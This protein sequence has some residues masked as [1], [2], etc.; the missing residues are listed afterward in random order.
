LCSLSA[1]GCSSPE[2][3]PKQARFRLP[4][5]EA[6]AAP[7]DPAGQQW[8]LHPEPVLSP[9]PTGAWDASDVLNPSVVRVNESFYNL[10][11]GFDGETWRTGLAASQDG[12]EWRKHPEPVLS[13]DP[14]TWEGGYIAANGAAFHDGER[15]LYWYHA[16]PRESPRIGLA[17]S[18]DAVHWTKQP[19]PVLEPGAPG[20]WDEA[21]VADPYAIRCQ[22]SYYL[23]FLG[24]NRFG[25]Q[26]LGVA[27]SPDGVHWQKSHTNPILD[28]GPPGSFDERGLGE[29]AVVFHGGRFF[30]LYTGRDS[31]E[32]RRL[33]W[34]VSD[35][36]VNWKKEPQARI[37]SVRRSWNRAVLCDATF[38]SGPE[39]LWM[40]FGGGD[41]PRPDE[42]LNGRIG[43]A[44]V[45]S[46]AS[47]PAVR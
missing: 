4:A 31:A 45:E 8:T 27:R 9:G 36:G 42:N 7:A 34:A 24:Q 19:A 22:G 41:R 15:F 18:Q 1:A 3:L 14:R 20:T 46:G 16:G 32:R 13:P 25:V 35:D 29:S 21:G 10:Y 39:R 6:A 28:A 40:W 33:G 30:L 23:F 43:V 12:I 2:L 11:S 37:L 44:I 38:W 5:C 17:F 47:I 26:R